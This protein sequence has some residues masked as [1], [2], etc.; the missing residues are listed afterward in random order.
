MIENENSVAENSPDVQLARKFL[1]FSGPSSQLENFLASNPAAAARM[2]KY[3]QAM[4]GMAKKGFAEGGST[5]MGQP[6]VPMPPAVGKSPD[7]PRQSYP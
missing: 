3:Q 7:D 5:Y 1:G 4:S 6:L 2:G